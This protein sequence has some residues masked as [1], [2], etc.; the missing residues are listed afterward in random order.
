MKHLKR[1]IIYALIVLKLISLSSQM[2]FQNENLLKKNEKTVKSEKE[3]NTKTNT[4]T[5]SN[6]NTAQIQMSST[7]EK[8]MTLNHEK[9]EEESYE[10]ERANAMAEFIF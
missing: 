4:N 10:L 7:M 5:I 3:K 8:P 9:N 6:L 2:Q 1:L